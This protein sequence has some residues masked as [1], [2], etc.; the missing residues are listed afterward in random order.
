M[1]K[2][3]EKLS[4]IKEDKNQYKALLANSNA[5]IKAGPGS[6]K[7]TVLT[8]KLKQLLMEKIVDP[9]G[10]VCLTY[11]NSAVKNFTQKLRELGVNKSNRVILSTVHGFCISQIL[12]PFGKIYDTRINFPI[13]IINKKEKKEIFSVSENELDISK[14]YT[15]ENVEEYRNEMYG[16]R[17]SVDI[18]K[19]KQ[20]EKLCLL[21][22]AKM[23]EKNLCD[24]NLIISESLRLIEE[25]PYILKC[26][27]A[28]FPWILIDEYQDLGKI[29]HE[30]VLLFLEKTKIK[31][32]VVGDPDQSIY[33][34]QGALPFY[35]LELYD[36]PDMKRINLT[37][38]Y[39]SDQFLIDSVL[40]TLD[41]DDREYVSGINNEK[42]AKINFF[43]C[44]DGMEQ[45][46][47]LV[48]QQL[49]P[50]CIA[51]DI[52]LSEICILVGYNNQLDELSNALDEEGIAYYRE[53]VPFLKL[54][55]VLWLQEC[56]LYLSG[57]NKVNFNDISDEWLFINNKDIRNFDKKMNLFK[58]LEKSKLNKTSFKKWLKEIFIDLDLSNVL[59]CSPYSNEVNDVKEFVIQV[60]KNEVLENYTVGQFGY[61]SVLNNQVTISTRHSSKGLEFEVVIIL[62][63]EDGSFPYYTHEID[64]QEY[65]EDLR[66]FFVS[67]TRAKRVVYLVRSKSISGISKYGNPYS[68]KKKPSP[69]WTLLKQN[70]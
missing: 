26:L 17:S 3:F 27:E 39:R 34:F 22:E 19:D 65:Q 2:Y 6:G 69:F 15:L 37:T 53:G 47:K 42:P 7:T 31:F 10:I 32:F 1:T 70:I 59:S 66:V 29:L 67:L 54:K 50:M 68:I 8:V 60:I 20:L 4:Q 9:R 51:N 35:F 12:I 14:Q 64:S 41:W 43:E 24:F 56:C 5:V 63:L 16:S 61:I 38:N 30:I 11:S 21:F 48:A 23:L 46:Y 49:I 18:N 25:C 52:S 33:K 44:E 45:Q 55:F 58:S 62:G 40:K 28:K 13:K 57:S 36:H